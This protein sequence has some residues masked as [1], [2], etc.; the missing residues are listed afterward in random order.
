[1]G[2]KR[3]DVSQAEFPHG[4]KQGG[5]VDEMISRTE[6]LGF[7]KVS[8]RLPMLNTALLVSSWG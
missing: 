2:V 1:M 4:G 6:K 7:P 3:W 8:P 5:G